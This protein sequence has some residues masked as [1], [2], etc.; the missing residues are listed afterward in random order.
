MCSLQCAQLP[1]IMQWKLMQGYFWFC[2]RHR[3]SLHFSCTSL[4][5]AG[6]S[7]AARPTMAQAKLRKLGSLHFANVALGVATD[8]DEGESEQRG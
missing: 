5:T 7:L 6:V 2:G 3:A 8:D 4:L 1:N